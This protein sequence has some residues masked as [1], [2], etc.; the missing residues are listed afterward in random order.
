MGDFE[1]RTTS[2]ADQTTGKKRLLVYLC[3]LVNILLRYV[4]SVEKQKQNRNHRYD[5]SKFRSC[6]SIAGCRKILE[7]S[8]FPI[9]ELLLWTLSPSLSRELQE[10]LQ[11]DHT[12]PSSRH[13]TLALQWALLLLQATETLVLLQIHGISINTSSCGCLRLPE[14]CPRK[15]SCKPVFAAPE[16]QLSKSQIDIA[17]LGPNLGTPVLA[18]YSKFPFILTK[19]AR[20]LLCLS[21]TRGYRA[22]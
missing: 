4:K 17:S 11:Y 21:R 1:C 22:Q 13:I 6:I 5:R 18:D 20:V 7:I 19:S 14:A 8:C 10:E 15:P 16:T 12:S 9:F 2:L 3:S